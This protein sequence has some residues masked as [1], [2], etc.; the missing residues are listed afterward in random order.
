VSPRGVVQAVSSFL[1]SAYGLIAGFGQAAVW[2]TLVAF[3]TVSVLLSF[4]AVKAP[5][6]KRACRA[7]LER[8]RSRAAQ[9]RSW[10]SQMGQGAGGQYMLTHELRRLALAVLA[11]SE[12]A[13]AADLEERIRS[14]HLEVDES[15]RWLLERGGQRGGPHASA[16][17][18]A[19]RVARIMD[20]LEERLGAG[21][22]RKDR[23]HAD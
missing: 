4:A 18:D 19:R 11:H 22:E 10:L 16:G 2:I 7:L 15:V 21:P 9:W 8:G 6:V 20:A 5:A 12:G 23:E 14:G 3:F 17:I 13:Q 1:W